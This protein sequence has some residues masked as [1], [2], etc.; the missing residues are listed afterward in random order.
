MELCLSSFKGA[1]AHPQSCFPA[2][3]WKG[4]R[5]AAA[6]T[7]QPRRGQSWQYHQCLHYQGTH[8][9]ADILLNSF[10]LS[11]LFFLFPITRQ[12]PL[13]A[14]SVAS[15]L[16]PAICI[17]CH[18]HLHP[19]QSE[20]SSP[21]SAAHCIT[22]YSNCQLQLSPPILLCLPS[23]SVFLSLPHPFDPSFH[24]ISFI[25]S[26]SNSWCKCQGETM[27]KVSLFV[28]TVADLITV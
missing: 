23:V 21:I 24:H 26:D 2:Q 13:N 12:L 7:T 28:C 18:Y 15:A 10:T 4:W 1:P 14:F 25:R 3:F 5:W 17:F 19:I 11:C 22:A 20:L 8:I 9:L 16:R 27:L 6:W